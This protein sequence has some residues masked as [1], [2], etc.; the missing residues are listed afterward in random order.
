MPSS[1]G[2]ITY[3]DA[4][5]NVTFYVT[6][7]GDK[8]EPITVVMANGKKMDSLTFT[9]KDQT[10]K[11]GG[12]SILGNVQ[13]D[14]PGLQWM[15]VFMVALGMVLFVLAFRITSGELIVEKDDDY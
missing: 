13:T 5:R 1:T 15:R 6:S 7:E 3:D 8:L 11:K 10:K 4:V 9:N 12:S 2:K 14:D